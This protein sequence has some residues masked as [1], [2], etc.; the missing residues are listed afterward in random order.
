MI[1]HR[2]APFLQSHV[3][4][5]YW[6]QY[7]LLDVIFVSAVIII[8]LFYLLY[9]IIKIVKNIFIPNTMKIANDK[10]HN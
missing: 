7:L 9:K 6:F 10:K 5:L 1:R 4:K 8:S 3:T 2:G